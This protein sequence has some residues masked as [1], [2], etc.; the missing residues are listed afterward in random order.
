VGGGVN[1]ATVMT[2][3]ATQIDTISGLRTYSYPPD[4]VQ[5]PAA[6]VTYPETYT[7]DSTFGRGTD[8]M[9]VPVIVMVG[10]VSDRKSRDQL[11]DY[12][13]GSGAKSLKAVVEAGTYTA[14]DSAR[15]E[16]V[17]FD[18]VQMAAV[19]YVAA[20]FTIHVAG[21]GS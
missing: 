4:N 3:L 11:G 12:V 18:I 5:V 2:Q 16:Q 19:E 20:T 1:L 10:R 15:V 13:N 21:S 7:Y 8:E 17:E 9:R 14:F 6:V